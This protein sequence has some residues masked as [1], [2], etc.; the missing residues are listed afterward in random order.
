[1]LSVVTN[2][3]PKLTKLDHQNTQGRSTHLETMYSCAKV[4][5][6]KNKKPILNM[7]KVIVYLF[8]LCNDSMQLSYNV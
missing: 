7:S 8:A 2:T 6:K 4:K 3:T 1:M 5:T